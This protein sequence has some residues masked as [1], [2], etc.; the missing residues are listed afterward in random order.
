MISGG[1]QLWLRAHLFTTGQ[2]GHVVCCLFVRMCEGKQ[3]NYSI[4]YDSCF[5]G[6]LGVSELI[7]SHIV[8]C[9][10]VEMD[11]SHF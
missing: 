3:C 6:M 7:K 11:H 5:V 1:T 8:V 4:G 10:D 2:F 9:R